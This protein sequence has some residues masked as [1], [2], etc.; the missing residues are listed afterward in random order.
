MV[1][2]FSVAK[3][4]DTPILELLKNSQVKKITQDLR[5]YWKTLR[6][7]KGPSIFGIAKNTIDVIKSIIKNEELSLPA[8]VL[9]KGEYGLSDVCLGVPVLINKEG[10]SRI[11]EINLEKSELNSLHESAKTIR[12]HIF[13]HTTQLHNL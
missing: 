2:I 4:Q 1:P 3:W 7:L 5:D 11:V 8:S 9:L 6:R 13:P 10:I 12:N